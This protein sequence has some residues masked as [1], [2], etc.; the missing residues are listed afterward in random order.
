MFAKYGMNSKLVFTRIMRLGVNVTFQVFIS[1]SLMYGTIEPLQ[2]V[3]KSGISFN[4]N[5]V[6]VKP[7]ICVLFPNRINISFNIRG[8]LSIFRFIRF[9][10]NDFCRVGAESGVHPDEIQE[11]KLKTTHRKGTT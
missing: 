6:C 2:P 9:V 8:I 10:C 4:N 1:T 11:T 5:S 3:P 7:V